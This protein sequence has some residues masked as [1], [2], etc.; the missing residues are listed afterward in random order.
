MGSKEARQIVITGVSRG[1]GRAMAAGFVA[2]GHTVHGCVRS[3][4]VAAE[5]RRVWP[6]PHSVAAVDVTDD[7]AVR[8]WADE[9]LRAGPPDLLINNAAIVNRNAPCGACRSRN[10]IRSSMSI[11]KGRSTCCAHS[12]PATIARKRG[13]IVNFSRGWGRST[14]PWVLRRMARAT[15][16]AIQGLTQRDAGT[17]ARH[18]GCAAEPGHHRY[19]HAV[20]APAAMRL[21]IR[22]R[23][24]GR[25]RPCR[26]CLGWARAI[27]GS[28]ERWT[29]Y[30]DSGNGG[31]KIRGGLPV[32]GRVNFSP[33]LVKP[34]T[35]PP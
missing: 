11:S 24:N 21:N 15:K 26:I 29:N 10:L 13:V 9:V 6:G 32:G 22:R 33:Y 18:G 30:F 5:L 19:G 28:R 3:A 27:T 34:G 23:R 35:K 16:W 2:A 8:V 1:L 31:S 25:R 12:V 20:P 7:V 17:T 4:S 14:S